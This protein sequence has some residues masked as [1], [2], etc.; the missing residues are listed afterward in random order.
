MYRNEDI[1]DINNNIKDIIENAN[2]LYRNNNDPTFKEIY[3]CFEFIKTFFIKK[4][5]ILYGG[6]A[7][8]LLIINKNKNDGFY[9]DINNI[10]L[11]NTDIADLEF[12]SP[13]PIN[14]L[15]ELC[16]ELSNAGFTHIDCKEGLHEET[17]KLFINFINY[18]DVSYIS[19]NIY[20]KLPIITI[21][22]IKCIHPH[23][24]YIDF[25]RVFVD[26]MTSYWRL[27]KS[28]TRFNKLIK[29][30]P[31]DIIPFNINKLISFKN[32][33]ILYY[34]KKHIIHKSKYIVIGFF[35]YNYYIKKYT[36][37]F[38][39]NNLLYYELISNNLIE[40]GNHILEKLTKKYGNKITVSEFSPFY[41]LFDKRFEYYYNNNLILCLYGNNERCIVYKYSN[42]KKI[43]FSTFNL[44]I[45]YL[46]INYYYYT[47]NN[48]KN[49]YLYMM[50][51]NKLYEIKNLYLIKYNK[52][53]LDD[54]PFQDFSL[55][56]IGEPIELKR[57]AMLNK[58]KKF[59]Y[60]P[61]KG[62]KGTIPYYIFNNKSGNK[63]INNKFFSLKKI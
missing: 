26:P 17:Y 61:K 63:I 31:L 6:Y 2:I 62:S 20:N 14:D 40:D 9:K 36:N 47:I 52:S 53:V 38:L 56:C 8:N 42:K 27:E 55:K 49:A 39:I 1:I 59:K 34:I 7:Q 35:A 37:K 45:L 18:C 19:E 29:Y 23:F 54:T 50:L 57:K 28:F 48:N 41:D 4:K 10:Y 32:N 46:L 24:M 3:N 13:K 33:D 11:H 15:I 58:I 12:Y 5:R 25:L 60:T 44:L 43:Y 16:D 30:Y 22:N 51:I 21:N